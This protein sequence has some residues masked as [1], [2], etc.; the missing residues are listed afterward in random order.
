MGEVQISC[1]ENGMEKSQR[2]VGTTPEMHGPH[3]P[4]QHVAESQKRPFFEKGLFGLTVARGFLVGEN[5]FSCTIHSWH[6]HSHC[7]L[8]QKFSLLCDEKFVCFLK[9]QRWCVREVGQ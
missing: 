8:Q 4:C 3:K 9:P 7:S 5:D 6:L 1:A 2:V